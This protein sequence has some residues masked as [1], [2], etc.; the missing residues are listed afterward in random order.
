MTETMETRKVQ[1]WIRIFPDK[2][3][4]REPCRGTYAVKVKSTRITW[5]A[6]IKPWGV[7]D[8]ILLRATKA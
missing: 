6:V 5:V 1:V 3:D 2:P 4:S 8:T 7:G